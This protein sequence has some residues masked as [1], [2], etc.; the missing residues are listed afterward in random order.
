M[1]R[2]YDGGCE[3]FFGN[4]VV[5]KLIADQNSRQN[6][7][8]AAG[9][10]RTIRAILDAGSFKPDQTYELQCLGIVLGDA[11]VQDLK[12]E[13]ARVEIAP[14]QDPANAD[15]KVVL[16]VTDPLISLS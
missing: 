9:K 11:F 3:S 15:T 4:P 1:E 5:E 12:M 13:W 6:Y 8:T 14:G 16:Y 10:L 2:Y 7:Q